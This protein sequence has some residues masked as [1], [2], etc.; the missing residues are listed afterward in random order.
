MPLLFFVG[1]LVAGALTAWIAPRSTRRLADSSSAT[2]LERAL[3]AAAVEGT[4]G[5]ERTLFRAL[6]PRT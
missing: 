3:H 2:G 6:A 4:S 1:G 5:P